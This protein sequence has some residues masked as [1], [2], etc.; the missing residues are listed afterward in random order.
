MC[1]SRDMRAIPGT[2]L[3]LAEVA[4]ILERPFVWHDFGGI[5][6]TAYLNQ[7]VRKTGK[8]LGEKKFYSFF[9]TDHLLIPSSEAGKIAFEVRWAEDHNLDIVIPVGLAR[10]QGE[11]Q[12]E[13]NITALDG[14]ALTWQELENLPYHA[15]Y[16]KDFAGGASIAA[17]Y[18]KFDVDYTWHQE[19]TKDESWHFFHD[20]KRYPRLAQGIRVKVLGETWF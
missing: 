5:G 3:T 13:T 8:A 11:R 7:G 16:G 18:G 2:A 12:G 14:K 9:I 10:N 4:R 20:N 15:I 1:I 19:D 6:I 17:Y